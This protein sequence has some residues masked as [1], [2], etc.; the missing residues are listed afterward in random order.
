M[1]PV[2][3]YLEYSNE[4]A[5]YLHLSIVKLEGFKRFLMS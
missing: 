2:I 5:Y 1:L 3:P 4:I